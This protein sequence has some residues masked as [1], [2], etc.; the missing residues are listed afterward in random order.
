MTDTQTADAS[1]VVEPVSPNDRI[2]PAVTIREPSL[3]ARASSG[4][5]SVAMV[6]PRDEQ[7]R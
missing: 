5:L 1:Q 3:G 2:Q 7:M 4:T 6:V